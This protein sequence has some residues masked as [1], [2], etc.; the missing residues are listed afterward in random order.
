M[1][2]KIKHNNKEDG[3]ISCDK[4]TQY[5]ASKESKSESESGS[6]SVCVWHEC[7][8]LLKEPF[9]AHM[10]EREMTKTKKK[11]GIELKTIYTKA[12]QSISGIGYF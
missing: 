5:V 3:K 7:M 12:L 1:F 10:F 2:T 11:H 4:Q 8:F 6:E 9:R